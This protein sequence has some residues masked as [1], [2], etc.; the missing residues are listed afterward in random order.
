MPLIPAAPAVADWSSAFAGLP[1]TTAP[2]TTNPQLVAATHADSF[3]NEAT[4]RYPTTPTA[5]TDEDEDS[6]NKITK[7]KGVKC[8]RF[9]HRSA[10]R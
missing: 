2:P 6:K 4:P 3:Y 9:G 5:T 8:A 7:L 10:L 1:A